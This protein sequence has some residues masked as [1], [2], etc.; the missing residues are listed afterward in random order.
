[1]KKVVF[2]LVLVGVVLSTLGAQIPP[3]CQVGIEEFFPGSI[4]VRVYCLVFP[5]GWNQN[6]YGYAFI[7][8]VGDPFDPAPVYMGA[9]FLDSRNLVFDGFWWPSEACPFGNLCRCDQY[10]AYYVVTSVV[11]YPDPSCGWCLPLTVSGTPLYWSKDQSCDA[12]P[13]VFCRR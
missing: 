7:K 13:V 2:G 1:M 4:R 6:S 8:R 12:L 5:V 10:R 9:A 11:L 3:P